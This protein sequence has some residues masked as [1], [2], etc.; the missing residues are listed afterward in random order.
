MHDLHNVHLPSNTQPK[1]QKKVQCF[2]VGVVKYWNRLPW[3]VG[4]A[5]CSSVFN[6]HLATALS[7]MLYLLVSHE[8]VRQLDLISEGPFQTEQFYFL[9]S[10]FY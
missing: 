3:E 4:D 5:S 1:R 10:Q 2:T 9:E 7:N 6:R 8:Q